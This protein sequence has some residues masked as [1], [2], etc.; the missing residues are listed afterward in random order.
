MNFVKIGILEMWILYKLGFS[1]WI[2]SIK[3]G[4]LPQCAPFNHNDGDFLYTAASPSLKSSML[5]FCSFSKSRSQELMSRKAIWR[6][7]R[8]RIV[9][10][11]ETRQL[12]KLES[13]KM[14]CL[15]SCHVELNSKC[16]TSRFFFLSSPSSSSSSIT[17]CFEIRPP[18][19]HEFFHYI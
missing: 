19:W 7:H 15:L 12:L 2:K 4:F 5:R 1:I 16:Y 10:F 17:V 18:S 6:S 13:W 8:V 11:S 3:C 9:D 14:W